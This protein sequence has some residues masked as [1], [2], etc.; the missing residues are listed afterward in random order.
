MLWRRHACP[1][2]DCL[3]GPHADAFLGEAAIW[4]NARFRG[5]M[6]ASALAYTVAP[7]ARFPMPPNYY[8]CVHRLRRPVCTPLEPHCS[9]KNPPCTLQ[10]TGMV[11]SHDV[12]VICFRCQVALQQARAHI[13]RMKCMQTDEYFPSA[14]VVHANVDMLHENNHNTFY[15]TDT[16]S[17]PS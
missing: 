7:P 14:S 9:S 5:R 12:Y 2:T 10:E 6:A 15:A 4:Q 13:R 16:T 11:L 8:S 3:P 17:N 1:V